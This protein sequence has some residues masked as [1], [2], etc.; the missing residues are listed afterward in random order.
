MASISKNAGQRSLAKLKLNSLWGKW[1]QNQNK[2]LTALITSEKEFQE[3]LGSPG[4]VVTNL[5]L[6]KDDVA[7]VSW[8]YS[9]DNVPQ[10]RKLIWQLLPT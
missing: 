8:R 5:I 1:A 7:F 3:L 6:P 10:G 9:E 2:T 4:I